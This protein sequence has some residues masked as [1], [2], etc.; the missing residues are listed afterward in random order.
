MND[1]VKYV[2]YNQLFTRHHPKSFA[3]SLHRFLPTKC[4][5]VQTYIFTTKQGCITAENAQNI[6]GKHSK[7]CNTQCVE[8]A[9]GGPV[10]GTQLRR[11]DWRPRTHPTVP[12]EQRTVG[13]GKLPCSTAQYSTVQC[14]TGMR[15]RYNAGLLGNDW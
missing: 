1:S 8:R 7:V 10:V 9:A 11:G 6:H 12:A 14:S 5:N 15:T 4:K 2:N 3:S 13:R